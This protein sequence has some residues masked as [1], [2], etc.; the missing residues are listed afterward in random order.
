MSLLST[1]KFLWKYNPLNDSIIDKSEKKMSSPDEMYDEA[2]TLKDSGDMDGAIAKLKSIL[3]IDE[4]HSHAHSA[5]AV[6]LQ[7]IGNNEEAIMH[8]QKVVELDP[9]DSFSYT[10][11]SVI[12]QRCGLIQEAEDAMA[13]ARTIQGGGCH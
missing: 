7:K 6:Y 9:E 2:V 11:L 8:A 10:Q 1:V 12:C 5:L 4:K 13:K 3:E